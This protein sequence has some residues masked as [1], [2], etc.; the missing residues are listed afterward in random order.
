MSKWNFDIVQK[1]IADT[2]RN[3]PIILAKQAENHF[4]DSFKKGALD[5]HKWQEVKRR[6]PGT[7]E[8]KYPKKKGLSRRITPILVRTGNLRRKVS[9]SIHEAT[10][11]RVRLVVDLPY[12]EAHNEGTDNIP[13][14]PFMIQ[15]PQLAA[16]QKTT[17]EK[18]IDKIWK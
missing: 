6:I 14:R 4:T 17:I 9:R 1:K 11:A 2:K 3:L 16:K 13:A 12:A 18:E 7:Y 15:T 10:F 5:S 8:Y